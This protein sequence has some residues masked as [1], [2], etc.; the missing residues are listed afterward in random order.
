MADEKDD[1]NQVVIRNN[2]QNQFVAN[3]SFTNESGV[4]TDSEYVAASTMQVISIK[5]A[6][7]E[8]FK[9][10]QS[11]REFAPY[12]ALGEQVVFVWNGRVYRVTK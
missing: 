10:V 11:N 5:F 6:S 7:D 1:S 3:K 12:L 8:Y 4:W 9:L 2:H